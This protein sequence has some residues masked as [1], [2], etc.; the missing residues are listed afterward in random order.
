[1]AG[2]LPWVNAYTVI[3]NL[4]TKIKEVPVPAKFT[5]DFL[6]AKL[7]LKSSSY[8]AMIPLLKKLDFLDSNGTPIDNY[9]DFKDSSKSQ[10]TMGKALKH[11]YA[12]LYEYVEYPETLEMNEIKEKIALVINAQSTDEK[13]KN[14]AGTFFSLKEFA[15]FDFNR[16][17]AIDRKNLPVVPRSENIDSSK[18]GINYTINIT[19]PNTTER[20]V[21]EVIFETMKKH[22]LK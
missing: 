4:L 6:S 22:L 16:P 21:F 9:K 12:K 5:H 1:M 14:I 7:Q 19:L 8:H 13:V 20:E 15:S 17:T 3:R 18:I 2:T 10:T 11:A